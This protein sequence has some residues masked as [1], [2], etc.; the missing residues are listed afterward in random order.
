[1]CLYSFISASFILFLLNSINLYLFRRYIF[2]DEK[3][4]RNYQTLKS[5]KL[6][7]CMFHITVGFSLFAS[8]KF[9]EILFSNYAKLKLFTFKVKTIHKLSP[10]KYIRIISLFPSLIA[11]GASAILYLQFK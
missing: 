9:I 8:H 6:K 5:S 10:Q 3:F 7:L 4:R 2:E 11:I 1:M